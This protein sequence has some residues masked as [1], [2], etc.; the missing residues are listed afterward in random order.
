MLIIHILFKNYFVLGDIWLPLSDTVVSS[1][2]VFQVW[3]RCGIT[4]KG[5]GKVTIT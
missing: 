2:T 4:A 3:L 5:V 1:Q